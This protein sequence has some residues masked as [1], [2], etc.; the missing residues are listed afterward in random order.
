MSDADVDVGA[1]PGGHLYGFVVVFGVLAVALPLV[2]LQN[3]LHFDEAIYLAVAE[4][5]TDGG[6]LYRDAIDHKSPGIFAVAAAGIVYTDAARSVLVAVPG[7]PEPPALTMAVLRLWTYAVVGLTGTLVA[8][9][10]RR[11]ADA[12]T[13]M[14]AGIAYLLAAYLPYFEGY[15]F[16]T[17]PW[18]V[19]PTVLAAVLL[20]RR[21]PWADVLAG[22][23]LAVGVLF[24]QTVFLFG[25]AFIV[26]QGLRFRYPD[27]RS[28][29]EVVRSVRRLVLIG[30]GFVVPVALVLAVFAA[31][32]TLTE[33]LYYT[34]V[35]PATSYQTPASLSG[36]AYAAVSLLPVWL[37]AVGVVA[38]V[39]RNLL[40]RRA[41]D[42]ELLFV[43]LW[44]IAVSYT[45]VTS[46]GAQHQL[47]FVFP[48]MAVLAAVGWQ[49]VAVA[50]PTAV[51]A[52][53]GL[54]RRWPGVPDRSTAA[55]VVLV[56]LVVLTAG[57]NG[58]LL[59]NALAGNHV[60]EQVESA[61]AVETRVDGPVYTWPPNLYLDVFSDE[62]EYGSRYYMGVYGPTVDGVIEDLE[63]RS[64]PYLVVRRN[65]VTEDGRIDPETAKWFAD[66][67]RPLVAYMNRKYEPVDGT[68]DYVIFRR[69][70]SG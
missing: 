35:L 45:G 55:V 46:F 61:E 40:R 42:D 27:H 33:M 47:L 17:E 57:F 24:N 16:I 5:V 37:L 53:G 9:L 50:R 20:F 41:V 13:G 64:V 18:A 26:Y 6:R 69:T 22:V 11:V 15:Y 8:L 31:R 14:V 23:A 1:S 12:R 58:L 52:D 32:G 34:F 56:V 59:G 43:V 29:A 28:A 49:H 4:R 62:L 25:L 51:R 60:D 3:P 70:D 2:Y 63:E 44:G 36:R 54:V 21:R 7:L 66:D 68:D 30:T 19:L 65:H 39:G 48:P 10:G 67:K 38:V